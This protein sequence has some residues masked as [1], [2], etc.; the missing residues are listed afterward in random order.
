[1]KFHHLTGLAVSEARDPASLLV[2]DRL[3]LT[4]RVDA[5]IFPGLQHLFLFQT[6][7]FTLLFPLDEEQCLRLDMRGNFITSRLCLHH[8]PDSFTT[9]AHCLGEAPGLWC[10]SRIYIANRCLD[11]LH[12]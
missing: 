1:M 9:V 7:A 11:S 10:G 4:F 5:V 3:P 6:L 8:S 12:C 2:S